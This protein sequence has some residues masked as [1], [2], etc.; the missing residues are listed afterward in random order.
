MLNAPS[1]VPHSSKLDGN[2]LLVSTELAE[3]RESYVQHQAITTGPGFNKD[4][5]VKEVFP[6]GLVLT[7]NSSKHLPHLECHKRM[8]GV[9]IGVICGNDSL[10]LVMAVFGNKPVANG[11][12]VYV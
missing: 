8:L 2:G 5:E 7:V 3:P 9:D 4:S 1:G 12:S 6:G 10:G 11:Q